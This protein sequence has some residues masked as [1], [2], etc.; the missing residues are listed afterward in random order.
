MSAN[1]KWVDTVIDV[2]WRIVQAQLVFH[3]AGS[4][5]LNTEFKSQTGIGYQVINSGNAPTVIFFIKRGH[6]WGVCWQKA[7]ARGNA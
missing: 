3:L 2:I 1:V 5:L 6:L 7:Q 4:R